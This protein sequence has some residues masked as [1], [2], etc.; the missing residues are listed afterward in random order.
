MEYTIKVLNL[1][2]RVD[3]KEAFIDHH[4]KLGYD[5]S[6]FNFHY[7]HDAA[8]YKTTAD[9]VKAMNEKYPIG[10]IIHFRKGDYGCFWSL[11]DLVESIAHNKSE[12]EYVL[13]SLDDS[14]LTIDPDRLNN[15]FDY[16]YNKDKD[17]CYLKLYW[18]C[19][20]P[21]PKTYQVEG[22]NFCDGLYGYGDRAIL[23]N[24]RSAG[25]ILHESLRQKVFI[26]HICNDWQA[27]SQQG[28]YTNADVTR[29]S[30]SRV[31]YHGEGL[32]CPYNPWAEQDRVKLNEE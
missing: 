21:A 3:R 30:T 17:F 1:K 12:S 32:S 27:P 31:L 7:G 8:D 2:R 26:E 25:L 18:S 23:L 19:E 22:F 28:F 29:E 14:Y 24:K 10:E 11:S 20:K 15:I 6:M 5:P 4:V 9:I 13:Y 16:F